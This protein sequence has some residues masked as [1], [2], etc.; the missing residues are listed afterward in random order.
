[1]NRREFGQL[2][3]ALRQDLDWTQATLA[4]LIE[5][6]EP[7]V[8]QIERGVKKHLDPDLLF[9]LANEL[10]LTTLERKEFFLAA[11]GLDEK[12]M[13]RQPAKGTTTDT[14]HPTK[15]LAPLLD[16]LRA[17]QVPAFL[18]DVYGDAI[19]MN[20][21][22]ANFFHIPASMIGTAGDVPGGYNLMRMTFDRDLVARS[23]V[24]ENWDEYAMTT[25]HSYR[26]TT[27]RYRAKPYFK[28]LLKTFRDPVVYPLFDRFWK[29][30]TSLESDRNTAADYF[31]YR[32]EEYGM[33]NYFTLSLITHTAF[34]ELFLAIYQP[35]DDHTANTFLRIFKEAGNNIIPLSPWPE[36]V[37]K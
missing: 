15:I 9:R 4:E 1:M 30:V 20:Q 18:S 16:T 37:I 7:V 21:T 17:L 29:R 6:D 10:K 5:E 13:V 28:H 24:V 8:S 26:A 32:H 23:H 3:A 14:F 19:A 12:Q 33:M 35:L 22:I 34:G 25:M 27:L 31:N 11:S 2:I 36:K